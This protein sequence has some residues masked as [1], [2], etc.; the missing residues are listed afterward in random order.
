METK[1]PE[2]GGEAQPRAVHPDEIWRPVRGDLRKKPKIEV[3]GRDDDDDSDEGD[4]ES[5][6]ALNPPPTKEQQLELLYD[7]KSDDADEMWVQTHFGASL[8]SDAVVSC[9]ACFTPLSY[10]TQRHEIYTNQFRALSVS[11]LFCCRYLTVLQQLGLSRTA[12]WI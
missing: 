4:D 7:P 2:K 12:L 10:V 8:K 3:I 11:A 1:A 5:P 6:G 9:P